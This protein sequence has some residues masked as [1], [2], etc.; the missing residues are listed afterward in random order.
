M[1][2]GY[3]IVVDYWYKFVIL[4][5]CGIYIVYDIIMDLVL[6]S[7]GVFNL[8]GENVYYGS[9]E[10]VCWFMEYELSILKSCLYE[11]EV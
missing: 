3:Y 4:C 8:D 9:V 2:F 10:V 5:I 11:Y 6:N 1:C 7:G